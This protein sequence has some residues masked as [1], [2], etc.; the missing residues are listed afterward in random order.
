MPRLRCAGP[1]AVFAL[2]A[3]TPATLF[4]T[5]AVVGSGTPASCTEA[6]FDAGVTAGNSG[7]GTLSFNCGPAPHLILVTAQRSLTG[8]IVI[9]G[10]GRI[11][12]SGGLATRIFWVQDHAPPR[13][14]PVA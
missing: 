4:A 11:T 1:F 14:A 6:T 8:P 3:L 10:G 12:L 13:L 2:V 9:D 5:S 7:G